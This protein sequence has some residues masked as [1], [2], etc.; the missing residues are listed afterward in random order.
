MDLILDSTVVL[1]RGKTN[2][3]DSMEYPSQGYTFIPILWLCT[4]NY[5]P[6]SGIN[7]QRISQSHKLPGDALNVC[8]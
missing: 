6:Y 7:I 4:I 8:F 1:K 5:S 2:I 3:S